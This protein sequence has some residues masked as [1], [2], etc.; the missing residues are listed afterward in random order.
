MEDKDK[1]IRQAYYNESGFASIRET[2][3]DAKKILNTITLNDV[4]DFLER[5]KTRQIKGYKGFNSYV[6]DH[7]LQEIQI[8]IAVFTDSAE[9]NKGFANC[10]V[11]V[12]MFTK[13]C[14]V[15]PIKDRKPPE[16]VRAMTEVL[17]K[18]GLPEN[19][20]SD[21]EGSWTNKAFIKLL[22]EHKIKHIITSSP[23]PFAE[24]MVQEIKNMIHIRLQGLEVEKENWVNL[25]PAVLKKYNNRIHGTTKMSPNEA[26]QN[27]KQCTSIFK[28]KFKTAI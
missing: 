22:N 8:D 10:F 15:V 3:K 13:F 17:E 18:I 6:A 21:H 23:P 16:S 2:Y 5:Q 19:I 1:I 4:K 27:Q 28:C 11:A 7:A 24:R 14:H 20:H 12:D 26:R 9:E 25:L